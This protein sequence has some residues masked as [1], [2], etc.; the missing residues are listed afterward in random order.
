MSKCRTLQYWAPLL[1]SFTSHAQTEFNTDLTWCSFIVNSGRLRLALGEP[2]DPGVPAPLS[3]II[4]TGR[5]K[6]FSQMRQ[7]EI[8]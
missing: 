1:C 2:G 3:I 7:G 6:N 8:A 4:G 5:S